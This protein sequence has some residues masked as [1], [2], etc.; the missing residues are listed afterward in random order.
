M[1]CF[2][3]FYI[4]TSTFDVYNYYKEFFKICTII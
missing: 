1:K 3:V 2:L 4:K